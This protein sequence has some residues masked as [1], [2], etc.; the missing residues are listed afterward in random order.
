MLLQTRLAYFLFNIVLYKIKQARFPLMKYKHK[1]PQS[2][3]NKANNEKMML[4]LKIYLA[5][6]A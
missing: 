1:V 5:K 3:T 4:L 6:Q 2:F